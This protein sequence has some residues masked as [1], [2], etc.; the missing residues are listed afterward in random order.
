MAHESRRRGRAVAGAE[1][2]LFPTRVLNRYGTG[3]VEMNDLPPDPEYMKDFDPYF[4]WQLI[5]KSKPMLIYCT[6]WRVMPFFRTL[7]LGG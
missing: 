6:Q 1:I 2:T 5:T 4:K 3:L 7:P